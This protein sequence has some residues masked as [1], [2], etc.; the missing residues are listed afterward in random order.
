PYA[1]LCRE[2]RPL[3]SLV[4]QRTRQ[5]PMDFG[6]ASTYVE[7]V[8]AADVEECA[9]RVLAAL[10]FDG[11]VEI[12]FKRD[13]RDGRLKLLDINPRVWGWHS[14]GRAAGVDFPY[15][16]WR[17]LRREQGDGRRGRAG[18]RRVRALSDLPVAFGELG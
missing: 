10:R 6:R 17:L 8:E 9:R 1:A 16:L 14:L 18:G 4:A 2:G 15:L 3:A 13:T 12:E 5:W 11:I 7:T